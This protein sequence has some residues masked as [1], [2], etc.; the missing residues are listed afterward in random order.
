MPRQKHF[1]QPAVD[2]IKQFGG[3]R[4]LAKALEISPSTISRWATSSVN[5]GTNGKIPQK[6]WSEIMVA[7]QKIGKP[8]SLSDLSGL[9]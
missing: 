8:I 6:Y 3:C 5:K 4:S 2:V 9:N 7:G 1:M